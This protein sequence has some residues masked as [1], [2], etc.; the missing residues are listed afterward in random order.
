MSNKKLVSEIQSGLSRVASLLTANVKGWSASGYNLNTPDIIAI[1]INHPYQVTITVRTPLTEQTEA[2]GDLVVSCAGGQWSTTW[3]MAGRPGGILFLKESVGFL[4]GNDSLE[5][6]ARTPGGT[7][8]FNSDKVYLLTLGPREGDG[9]Y[10]GVD[11]F[12]TFK[13]FTPISTS[14]HLKCKYNPSTEVVSK[15]QLIPSKFSSIDMAPFHVALPSQKSLVQKVY[16]S[17]LQ[18]MMI[19]PL[20]KELSAKYDYDVDIKVKL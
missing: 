8:T 10:Q 20:V 2:S 13:D 1:P 18:E 15:I 9:V 14:Y 6:M 11:I 12:V 3:A 5:N 7:V 17:N 4:R 16:M 19:D